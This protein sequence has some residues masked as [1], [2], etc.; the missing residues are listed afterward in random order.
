MKGVEV[1]ILRA[2]AQSRQAESAVQ[3]GSTSPAASWR[4]VGQPSAVFF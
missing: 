1:G 3:R 4:S 2:A